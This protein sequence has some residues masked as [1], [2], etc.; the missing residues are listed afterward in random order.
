MKVEAGNN[1][2]KEGQA[3]A[4][5]TE[6]QSVPSKKII[7][8][9]LWRILADD[10]LILPKFLYF[11]LNL[12]VYST[13]T[14]TA[15]YFFEEWDLVLWQFGLVA[16][17]SG[18]NFF[19]ALCWSWIADKTGRHKLI[20]ITC[21]LAYAGF[22][23]MLNWK[24]FG[25][26]Q[27]NASL[28]YTV[29]CYGLSNFC[30]SALFPLLDNQVFNMLAST[31]NFSKE[32]FGRVRLWGTVGHAAI[33]IVNAIGMDS[34]KHTEAEYDVM[35]LNLC[36]TS[37][38]CATL[39]YFCIPGGIFSRS[40]I[41]HKPPAKHGSHGKA[42]D[43]KQAEAETIKNPRL[44]LLKN[45]HF[46]FFL[47]VVLMSG[48]VRSVMSYFLALFME[49]DMNQSKVLIALSHLCR[50]SSEVAVFFYGKEMNKLFG[51][52]WLLVI[53]QA[54]GIIRIFMYSVIPVTGNWFFLSFAIELLK[55]INTAAIISAA[56]PIANSIAPPGAQASAQGL[57]SGVYSGLSAALGGTLGG[58]LGFAFNED[59]QKMFLL[60]SIVATVAL[61]MFVL[62]YALVDKVI[63]VPCLKKLKATKEDE[64]LA[65][66]VETSNS[67]EKN[68]ATELSDRKK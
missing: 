16:A 63:C 55:G 19:G 13:H 4:V 30:V 39:T 49:K 44:K 14:F 68:A 51:V 8:R 10:Y 57:F 54:C 11:A 41:T 2:E 29:V 65:A 9:S 35:F 34:L 67:K 31:K 48:Y 18:F 47:F 50:M 58:G 6:N 27:A 26:N 53:G 40:R 36:G 33:T 17:L 24:P 45:P 3:E 46:L 38:L 7:Y 56:I 15:Q 59:M 23:T 22:F 42:A 61:I 60:T 64:E 32:R 1:A 12:A 52:Y 21:C 43:H 20:L 66:A 25:E 37:I 5:Q 28:A 62:K